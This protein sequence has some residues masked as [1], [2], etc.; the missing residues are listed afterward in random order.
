MF[1]DVCGDY[2]N[3][4]GFV[5]G[6]MFKM[7]CV[8]ILVIMLVIMIALLGNMF[9]IDVGSTCVVCVGHDFD[10]ASW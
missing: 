8:T 10:T 5:Y 4:V 2:G 3:D 9:Y 7:T 1:K 6:N